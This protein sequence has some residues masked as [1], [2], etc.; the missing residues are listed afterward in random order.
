MCI[1]EVLKVL[2]FTTPVQFDKAVLFY[3]CWHEIDNEQ[4]KEDFK[5]K[6]RGTSVFF[7]T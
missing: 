3:I 4:Y 6:V 1:I 2:L 5:Y 7:N